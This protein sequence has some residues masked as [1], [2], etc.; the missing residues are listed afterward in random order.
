MDKI[1][2]LLN[3][4]YLGDS[5][6]EEIKIEQKKISI[7]IDCISRLKSG[8]EKWDYYNEENIE[9]GCLVFD[10]VINYSINSNLNINDEIYEIELVEKR[11]DIYYFKVVGCNISNDAISTDIEMQIEAKKFYIFNRQDNC[12]ISE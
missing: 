2:K 6:C 4:I 9:H 7:Q 8:T 1:K 11:D 12:I 5:F 3:T 10:E